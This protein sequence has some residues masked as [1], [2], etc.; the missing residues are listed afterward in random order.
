MNRFR[1]K[2]RAKDE[3]AKDEGSAPEQSSMP[4]FKSF[5]RGKKSSEEEPK[6]EF[7]LTSALPSDDNFRTSLLMTN[8]SA[9]FSMLREQDDPNTKIGKASDDS[10]LF[11]RRQS[12]MADFGFS[13][14]LRGLDDIAEVESIK[15]PHF[16]NQV[17]SF[18]SDDAD[19]TRSG[20][21]MNRSKPTDGNVLFG[22]RQKI[23]KIP[24]S[25]AQSGTPG[26]MGGRVLYDDD[27]SLSAFQLW[28]QNERQR[29]SLE[30]DGKDISAEDREGEE[31]DQEVDAI[32]STSPMF[33]G[34]NRRRETSSTTSS[35]SAIAR[36]STAATSIT[37][38][39][40]ASASVKE[41]QPTSTAASSTSSTPALERNVTRT[42][43][44]YE[45]ALTQDMHDQQSSALSRMD[46]LSRLRPTVNRTPDLAQVSPSPTGLGFHERFGERRP[47]LTKGSAPNLRSFSPSATASS[48]GTLDP[49][50]N[51]KVPSPLD[52]K[53]V[54]GGSPP[55]SPP[56]S[57]T[58]EHPLLPIHSNDRGK[59]T[60]MGVFQKPLG[61]YDESKYAQRQLQLQQGRETPNQRVRGD[62]NASFGTTA[63]S[64]SSSSMQRQPVDPK[65][66]GFKRVEPTV[67]EESGNHGTFFDDSDDSAAGG[68]PERGRHAGTPQ[69]VLERPADRDH[70][71]FRD[72][73]ALQTPLSLS[74]RAMGEHST[75]TAP[76]S[77]QGSPPDS[78]TLGP[79]AGLSGM[80]RQHL[81]SE[82]NSSSV[83]G[84]APQ[85]AHLPTDSMIDDG[86]GFDDKPN[87][88]TTQGQNWAPEQTLQHSAAGT[89]TVP[90]RGRTGQASAD[91]VE[92]E[93]DEFASQLADARRRVRERLTSYAE[94]DSSRECSP[95]RHSDSRKDIFGQPSPSTGNALG[96]GIVKPKS[97]RGSLDRSR[98]ISG[99]QSKAMKMLGIGAVTMATCPSPGKQSFDE[100]DSPTLAPMQE[101]MPAEDRWQDKSQAKAE[102]DVDAE[103]RSEEDK[104]D[105]TVHPGLRA[106][107]QARREL[108]RRK[109]LETLAK[110]QASQHSSPGSG[111]VSR[112]GSG[113]GSG[114]EWTDHVD[115]EA[116]PTPT[117]DG[118]ARQ[119][120]LN[121][122]HKPPP[123]FYQQRVS[124]D[125]SR[126]GRGTGSHPGS[127][128]TSTERNRSGSEA[129]GGPGPGQSYSRPPPRLQNN[130]SPHDE[131]KQGHH[132]PQQQ[133]L[134]PNNSSRQPM[135]RSPGL[136]GLPGTDI[137][138]SPI[139]P[140]QGYPKSASGPSSA[141]PSPHYL[142]QAHSAA[143]L[144]TQHSR[145]GYESHSGQPS[146]VSPLNGP[147]AGPM[148]IDENA[149][150]AVNKN[151]I[152]EP[153]FIM[154]TS[155]VPT[156]SLPEGTRSR[157][158]TSSGPTAP[159]L[160][161]LNPRRKREGSGPTTGGASQYP[162]RRGDDE[163][164]SSA[165]ASTSRPPMSGP[166][167]NHDGNRGTFTT[168]DE[169]D[170]A[171]TDQRRRLRK[172]T[173]NGDAHP[174]SPGFRG[175]PSP[176]QRA[177]NQN[178]NQFIA[179]GPPASRTVLTPGVKP[180]TTGPSGMF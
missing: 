39:P 55:L 81:R 82:S 1:T 30:L 24:A 123:V 102:G 20:S 17:D 70:P 67:K 142:D 178:Q 140:P 166:N 61:T 173:G 124:S 113:S 160:P 111:P 157:S 147:M 121:R 23:Y 117:K 134:G 32:R 6:K 57:E 155:R 125:E 18:I 64:R 107:R 145:N 167:A 36:N 141:M 46:T 59:A 110:H 97:S 164:Y 162:G 4:S 65:P 154:S 105:D 78:P 98:T 44:L 3:R 85:S 137:R 146:P 12:R 149:K 7:D 128:R 90:E 95:L 41:F 10:V 130:S 156:V 114:S 11:P 158:G 53:N 150:R 170:N 54:F 136:P 35:A 126:Y 79:T 177:A 21:I 139:M 5:R 99:P 163:V 80:V 72:E 94:T 83:Y 159:P 165:N 103:R 63:R 43:R 143:N 14:G 176:W 169:E 52:N 28:R 40:T 75:M 129:S 42:R 151:E 58:G 180:P 152:S 92:P 96:L 168:S 62:S 48:S 45:Q 100:K 179:A 108:Q 60:A 73:S 109:E 56:I 77:R 133:Q 116:K 37:S 84:A 66:E 171:Q 50:L 104:E 2:K 132:Q 51:T 68:F 47:I 25:G 13:S 69:V 49:G 119:G 87:P 127:R 31:A 8:L 153:T 138:R 115:A 112:S 26:G 93:T 22:G 131:H 106:F 174:H 175:P 144:N 16:R 172:P 29:H 122:E 86:F 34:Y 135:L 15:A 27:V 38:Q 161:P 118:R 74:D 76:N 101:E 88:W 19:S 33:V 9:R 71:A 89:S 148:G 120:T 91:E